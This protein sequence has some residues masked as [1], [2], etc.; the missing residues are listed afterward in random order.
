VF[1]AESNFSYAVTRGPAQVRTGLITI[2]TY[3]VQWIMD[4]EEVRKL[5]IEA[6]PKMGIVVGLVAIVFVVKGIL[7]SLATRDHRPDQTLGF[8]LDQLKQMR[9][10]GMITEQEFV[11]LKANVLHELTQPSGQDEDKYRKTKDSP[12]K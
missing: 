12:V 1:T 8:D 3:N 9:D 4:S 7:K 6:L 10:D 5:L 11:H 2:W